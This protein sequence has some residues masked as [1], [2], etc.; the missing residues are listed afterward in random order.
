M[1]G[2]S[3]GAGGRRCAFAPHAL[4]LSL[5]MSTDPLARALSWAIPPVFHFLRRRKT[6]SLYW[7]L[8]IF[9]RH[10]APGIQK[11]SWLF[12]PGTCQASQAC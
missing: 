7:F 5:H 4:L 12:S 9:Y 11:R 10:P 8:I 2:W 3:Q 1:A 6:F